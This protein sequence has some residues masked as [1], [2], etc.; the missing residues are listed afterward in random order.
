MAE[1]VA[2]PG[3]EFEEGASIGAQRTVLRHIGGGSRF[4][5]Y[6][7]WDERRLA[8]MVAKLLR[9]D[10]VEDEHALT[11]L[12]REAE[13]LDRLAHPMI[14]RGFDAVLSGPFPH[15]LIEHL[16]GWTLRRVIRRGGRLGPEQLLPLALHVASALHYLEAEGWVHLDVKPDNIIMGVPPRLI[17]LSVARTIER[18]GRLRSPLG[19]DPY[20]APE[21][22]DPQA[23]PGQIGPAADVWGLGATLHHAIAGEVPFDRVPDARDS[24]DPLVRFPQLREEPRPLPRGTPP[25]LTDLLQAALRRDPAERTSAAELAAGL[26]PLVEALP[27]RMTLGRRGVL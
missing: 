4:D 6:L 8:I 21:Q 15:L 2:P 22:C 20:M 5:V 19:T 18:A 10:L 26:E 9:P 25:E 24:P 17:D 7:V 11:E 23:Y 27:R 1:S 16:E 13:A 3:W 12:R 14:V